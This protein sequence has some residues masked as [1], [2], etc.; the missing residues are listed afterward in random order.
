MRKVHPTPT[1]VDWLTLNPVT[2]RAPF[3][4]HRIESTPSRPPEGKPRSARRF[5]VESDGWHG[6]LR[7]LRVVRGGASQDPGARGWAEPNGTPP[8]AVGRSRAARWGGR[9]LQAIGGAMR[10][11]DDSC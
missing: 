3:L 5:R 11:S 9:P 10:A 7:W 6:R 2:G 4:S 1:A 8:G